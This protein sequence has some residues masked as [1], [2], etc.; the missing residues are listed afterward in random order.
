MMMMMANRCVSCGRPGVRR[1]ETLNHAR[2]LIQPG[3]SVAE[4]KK[5]RCLRCVQQLIALS[6]Q[7]VLRNEKSKPGF[8][9]LRR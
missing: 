4:A 3:V 9:S 5:P 7:E 6:D 2:L 1:H 8:V